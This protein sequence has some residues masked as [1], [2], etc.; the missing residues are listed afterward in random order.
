MQTDYGITRTYYYEDRGNI[1]YYMNCVKNQTF[2]NPDLLIRMLPI[3]DSQFKTH[4]K[5]TYHSHSP[6]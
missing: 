6:R 2:Y 3:N 5:F 1:G 4:D